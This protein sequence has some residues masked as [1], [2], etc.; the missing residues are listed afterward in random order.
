[1]A[2]IRSRTV[3]ASKIVLKMLWYCPSTTGF[4][5]VS[6]S[7]SMSMRSKSRLLVSICRVVRSPRRSPSRR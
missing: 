2:S 3:F 5:A 7:C 4:A 1:M 6:V